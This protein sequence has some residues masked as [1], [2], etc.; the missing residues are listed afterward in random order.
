VEPCTNGHEVH[1]LL[2]Y[3]PD[4]LNVQYPF[5]DVHDLLSGKPFLH[6]GKIALTAWGVAILEED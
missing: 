4:L 6:N 1:Y 2:N 5:R 3:S